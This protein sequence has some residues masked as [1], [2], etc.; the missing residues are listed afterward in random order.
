MMSWCRERCGLSMLPQ[1]AQVDFREYHVEQIAQG[2][3]K[4]YI[5]WPRAFRNY[6]KWASP[7]QRFHAAKQWEQWLVNA[8]KLEGLGARQRQPKRY[9]P[10]PGSKR[11]FDGHKPVQDGPV[12]VVNVAKNSLKKLLN[13]SG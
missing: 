9:H 3:P 12:Q 2:K 1:A 4:K 11:E 8:K 6:I 10:D 13:N 7:G 5:N